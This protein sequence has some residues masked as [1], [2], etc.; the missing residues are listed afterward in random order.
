MCS[1][2]KFAAAPAEEPAPTLMWPK[3]V[4][5]QIVYA[6]NGREWLSKYATRNNMH[7]IICNQK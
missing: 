6:E 1:Y 5:L 7:E 2:S 3:N 4:E